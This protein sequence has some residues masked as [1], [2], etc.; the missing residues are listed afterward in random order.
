MLEECTDV[1]TNI[2]GTTSLVEH[3]IKL[4]TSEPIRFKGYPIPYQSVATVN[5]EVSNM[6]ELGVI[7]PLN[8]PFSSPLVLVRTKDSTVRLCIDF[9]QLN[10]IPGRDNVGAD[11]LSRLESHVDKAVES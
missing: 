5:E 2:L 7:E 6:L 8:A 1:L 11:Y 4:N 3:D 9:R 10:K